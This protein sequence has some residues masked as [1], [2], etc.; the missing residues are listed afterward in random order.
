MDFIY[1]IKGFI[2]GFVLPIPIGPAGILCIR[3]TIA[4]GKLH[5]FLTGLSAA[6]SDMMY[7]IVAAFGITLVSSFIY[8]H[9]HVIRVVGG[10]ILFVLGYRTLRPHSI[11]ET[12]THRVTTPIISFLSTFLVTLTNPMT[13]FAFATIF[14]TIGVVDLI[15]NH[16]SAVLLVAG[17]FAGSL[18]W[19][20]LLT[21]LSSTF[22]V[23]IASNS[24]TLLNKITGFLLMLFGIIA[25]VTGLSRF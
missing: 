4:Q 16:T 3:R 25:F 12:E 14:V 1:L 9:Q 23:N 20:S 17:V 22:K 6:L 24:L 10:I 19:F 2:I 13:V 15:H 21:F 7:S 11:G 8:Q 18:S 5:G